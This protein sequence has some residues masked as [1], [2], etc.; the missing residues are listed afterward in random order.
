M[1]RLSVV[2][3]A[4]LVI[5]GAAPAQGLPPEAAGAL[6]SDDVEFVANLPEPGAFGGRIMDDTLYV[7][8]TQGLRI[9]DVSGPT[10]IPV[11]LGALPIPHFGNEDVDTNGEILLIS[12]DHGLSVAN[13]LYV[14]D[15]SN[16]RLP[17]LRSRF[18]L[19]I[20][21]HTASCIQDC[22]FA[23]VAGSDSIGVVDLRDPAAPDL[24]GRFYQDGS[25][26]REGGRFGG[27]THDVNVDDAGLAWVSAGSGLF[28]YDPSDPVNP[29][30]VAA[31]RN[32]QSGAF[33]NNFIV[34]NSTRPD[35]GQVTAQTL[36]DTEID[37]GEVVLVTEEN[38]I[39]VS[40]D[41][42]ENDGSFQT[43]WVRVEDGEYVVTKL[44]SVNLGRLGDATSQKPQPV[45]TCSSHYFDH[46]DDGVVAVT[47]YEQG[48]RFFDVSDPANIEQ[49]GYF[50]PADAVTVA[51]LWHHGF[52]YTFDLVRG[53]DVLRYTGGPGSEPVDGPALRTE[54]PAVRPVPGF[55]YACRVA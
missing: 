34:H 29:T 10:G 18:P 19:S 42:C 26:N 21:A 6:A 51:A 23:W 14:V 1:R 41:L 20:R 47:W 28:A 31:R 53:M 15:V 3:V 45:A 7:T 2:F 52:L 33:V 5:A 25:S 17:V 9:F 24:V 13:T 38:W 32:G 48:T 49:I 37:P 8:T 55:G 50:L 54:H 36:A 46:R 11:P 44:D 22:D 30:L 39:S 12:T 27:L 43:G 16:P 35:A 4:L 40:N